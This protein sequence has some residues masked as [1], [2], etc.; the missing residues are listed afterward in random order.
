MK[1]VFTYC[2]KATS[3][4][5]FGYIVLGSAFGLMMTQSGY[6]LLWTMLSSIIV[7]AGSMQ[8]LLV[9]LL[10][11]GAGLL[12]VV[13]MTLSLNSR[14]IFYGLSYLDK[15]KKMGKFYPYMVFSLTDE[16]Y[17][18]LSSIEVP[19]DLDENKV[20]V[21]ISALNQSYWILGS[22][23]GS[24]VGD[25]LP[26]NLVGIEFSMTALFIVLFLEKWKDHKNRKAI[27][28]GFFCA[29]VCLI[30]LGSDNF[31]LPSLILLTVFLLCFKKRMGYIGD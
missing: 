9:S 13:M 10:H 11:N 15:F 12:Y 29:I 4:I 3:P 23:V 31:I 14:H 16:T 25:F 22:I 18:L 26:Q 27:Y 8:F 1:K 28:V 2:L 6:G 5:F 24:V 30:V 21:C 20:F 19:D 17:S 7:Y